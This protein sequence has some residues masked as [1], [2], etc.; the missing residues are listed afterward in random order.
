MIH[1]LALLLLLIAAAAFAADVPAAKV[2]TEPGPAYADG[3]RSWQGIPGIERTKGGRLWVTWYTG[4][5][6][7][8]DMGNYAMAATS[9]DDGKTWSKPMVIEGSKG[10]RIGD[11]LP[12]I[13][14][15]GRLWIF[16]TQLTKTSLEPTARDF[17]G[18]MAIRTDDPESAK[19][20][21]SEPFL[22]AEGGI[23]FGKPI[24]RA[25]GGWLAPFCINGKT[26]WIAETKGADTGVLLSA[27]EGAT[28]RWQ[29]GTTMPKEL[30][31]FAEATLAPRR[32]GSVWM[33]MRTTKGLYESASG[34]E[35]RMW[36]DPAPMPN[37]AGPATRAHMRRLAS[38]AFLLIYHDSK[39]A[40]PG[41]ERLTAWLSDDE[42]RTWPHQ[43]LL[44]ERTRVSY[45]DAIQAADGRIYLT[46][47]HGRY[48]TGEKE[49][50]VS[51][52]SEDDVR[53]G[54]IVSPDSAV[55]LVVNQCSGH[56]N[57]ADLRREAAQ[58]KTPDE[59]KAVASA[60]GGAG[61][62]VN[63]IGM[64][65]VRIEPG[66]FQMGQDGPRADYSTMKHGEKC[67]D[68]DWDERPV[69]RVTIT[70]PMHMGATE[71][72]VAQYRQFDPKLKTT[73]K[74]D[75][76]VT[77]VSWHDAVKFCEWLSAKEG[78]T[79]RLPTEAEW[80]YACRAGTTTPFSTGERLPDGFQKFKMNDKVIGRFFTK[81]GKFPPDYRDLS[82]DAP[83]RVAQTPAN[84]WGLSDMHG[85]VEEWCLDWYGPYEAAD[86]TDPV[87]RVDGDFRVT[88]G[89]SHDVFS[90][91]L[92]S[93]NRSGRLMETANDQIGFRVVLGEMPKT[94]PLPLPAPPLNARNVS[95][96]PAPPREP[97]AKPFFG[98]PKQ[99]VKVP[100][101]LAGPLFS[102]HNHSPAIAECPNGDL[103][104]VW[105]SCG[106]EGGPEL[107][108]IAS[109]LRRG[110]SEWEE[111]SP[112]WDGPDINDHA[113]KLWF[114][115]DRTLYFFAKGLSG[116]VMRTST[117]SG[118]T[119]SKGQVLQPETEV[120]N[121]PIRTREGFLVLPLDGNK[122]GAN[123]N[124]SR[125]G[126]KTWTF[127]PSHG[128]PD[129]RPGVTSVRYVGIHNAIEQLADGRFIAFGRVDTPEQQKPFNF[130]TP[131]GYSSDWG[132][133]WQLEASEFPAIGSVQRAVLLRLK[134][135][136][137]LFC[138]FTD[139]QRYWPKRKG[140]TFKAADG[141]EFTGYGLFAAVSF[142]DGKS[143]PVRRLI[144]PGGPE[145]TLPSVDH[146]EFT[147]SDTMS[148][149]AGY[150]AACQS[151]DG[152]VQLI[153]SKNHYVFNLAW[154]K[155]L[156][157]A[158]AK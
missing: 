150:L 10:T 154:L 116:D 48:E 156:P 17:K 13:D 124:I 131:V 7:E 56:G 113:P 36:S 26:P 40:K 117:D 118:A 139:E 71:V 39:K 21:W 73:G 137:L 143:W 5:T 51:I 64:K 90:R 148:E 93:A 144:T 134:E 77:G 72:T 16:Y 31:S 66:T 74:D 98:G 155:E 89:G 59:G 120:G 4:D 146:R 28:W 142:D 81:A 106:D 79:Y 84:Q 85:N 49:I 102:N 129:W 138:S 96:T 100:P 34:D 6:G 67:D 47:D 108:V 8:G 2:I 46:Y 25:N 1:K 109:R 68:A 75:E 83:L 57:H 147:L 80:E 18:T 54:K 91:F 24:V 29:G 44:D 32:D 82:K 19:P 92:R 30:W 14:P 69:H 110:A 88:R 76:A 58:K 53:A 149:A 122:P 114:D 3:A 61:E 65:L 43:L 45:P 125:D 119:W 111:A 9:G 158:P 38:G 22:V 62:M 50:V 37:F 20:K 151:R 133:T 101:D 15:K 123:F 107:A 145:R 121:Q 127:T 41:R 33:V 126:G 95:Q 60:A 130:R 55:Q 136:P 157:A 23:L 128:K 94:A 99:F 97:I 27:D 52:V 153:S 112:F 86:A 35:G 42:G 104:A 141:S 70:K 140:M 87:G 132:K 105:F 103:L 12:W 152:M 11:P 115:G 135:G 63:S 78:R